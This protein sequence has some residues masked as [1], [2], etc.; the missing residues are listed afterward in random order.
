MIKLKS[1][2]TRLKVKSL[3]NISYLFL[4]LSSIRV[5]E[6]VLAKLGVGIVLLPVFGK[7]D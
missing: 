5:R 3:Y 4:W 6:D 1:L 2:V 7:Y